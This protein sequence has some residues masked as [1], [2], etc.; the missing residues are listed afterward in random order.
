[1]IA[2]IIFGIVYLSIFLTCDWLKSIDWP[3]CPLMKSDVQERKNTACKTNLNSLH[4][5]LSTT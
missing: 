3:K 5:L 4:D 1:M 2:V